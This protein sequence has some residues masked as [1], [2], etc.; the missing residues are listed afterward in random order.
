MV[1]EAGTTFKLLAKNDIGERTLASYAIA[2]ES[3]FIRTE[4]NLYRVQNR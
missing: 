2:N 4:G 1:L 3:I